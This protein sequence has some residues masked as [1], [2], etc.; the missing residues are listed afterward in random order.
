MTHA[1]NDVEFFERSET[2]RERVLEQL[3]GHR[4][5]DSL[6]ETRRRLDRHDSFGEGRRGRSGLSGGAG[7]GTLSAGRGL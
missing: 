7:R 3:I 1:A 6:D 4:F 5:H 2:G